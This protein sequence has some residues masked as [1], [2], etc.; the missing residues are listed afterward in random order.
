M[1]NTDGGPIVKSLP[2][3]THPRVIFFTIGYLTSLDTP[4]LFLRALHS[5]LHSPAMLERLIFHC[6]IDY[7]DLNRSCLDVH[8]LD[9]WTELDSLA[10]HPL[11]ANLH[12]VTIIIW[13]IYPPDYD[14]EIHNGR[15]VRNVLPQKLPL[16]A[17]KHILRVGV[18]PTDF[19]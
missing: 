3:L 15:W 6:T 17:S 10:A 16:L 14:D 9:I 11:Y 7:E 18:R 8:A 4:I 12:E 19:C 13:I 1:S 5:G 2:F